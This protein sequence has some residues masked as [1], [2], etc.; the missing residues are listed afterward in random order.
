MFCRSLFVLLYFFFFF[1][2]RILIAP[3]V[4][5]NS[6]YMITFL[7]DEKWRDYIINSLD[8]S[9]TV[10]QISLREEVW[11]WAHIA[12]LTPS[13]FTDVPIPSQE[14]VLYFSGR[15][16]DSASFYDFYVAFWNCSDSVVVS[17]L[18][19]LVLFVVKNHQQRR[20]I[21]K[22]TYALLPQLLY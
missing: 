14:S 17:V 1:D 18:F 4:S 16:I 9:F 7:R 10:I 5:P 2:I 8:H 15:R 13:R 20:Y 11:V 22:L 6:P 12:S 3:L 21:H 19:I